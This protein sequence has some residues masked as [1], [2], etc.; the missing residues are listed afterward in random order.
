MSWL[1]LSGVVATVAYI[2]VIA[3]LQW[4]KLTNILDLD[5]NSFGD[6]LAGVLGPLGL[7]WLILSFFQQGRE[8]R[9]SIAS[10]NLQTYELQKIRRASEGIG[11]RGERATKAAA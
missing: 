2:G 6:F 11:E 10:L 5:L 9:N 4:G 7:F 3:W 1:G 8:L